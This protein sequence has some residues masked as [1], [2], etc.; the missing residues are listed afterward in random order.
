MCFCGI[1]DNFAD[2]KEDFSFVIVPVGKGTGPGE[3]T[4]D[5]AAEEF[6][7][8]SPVNVT[9]FFSYFTD[10]AGLGVL[11]R[12]EGNFSDKIIRQRVDKEVCA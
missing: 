6:R 5:V 10:V 12:G 7:G 3:E 11:L 9:V 1:G 8:T 4:A 2:F